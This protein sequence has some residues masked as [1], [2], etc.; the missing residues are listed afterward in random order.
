LHEHS[1]FAKKK[2]LE[3]EHDHN[4]QAFDERLTLG[5]PLE[6][7]REWLTQ[8]VAREG[9]DAYAMCLATTGL[10]GGPSARMVLLKS[11]DERG[12][13]FYTNYDSLK[14][15]EISADPRVALTFHW[16][17]LERQVR[18]LGWARKT[19]SRE[20]TAY[21]HSR[22]LES[23]ISAVISPQSREI[24]GRE[25]LESLRINYLEL[26]GAAEPG[27][28]SS[29]GGY[30]VVPRYYEFWQGRENRLHDR[31]F[32]EKKKGIWRSGYLA[33]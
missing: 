29:W 11:V 1:N 23:R 28:P 26:I 8:A 31:V 25:H 15:A 21:F 18:V 3:T 10:S 4:N 17:E 33:P 16:K 30:R 6:I 2:F 20:S 7:F 22:P 24:P 9:D 5:D 13:V 32:F 14:G 12:L 19:G 27:R